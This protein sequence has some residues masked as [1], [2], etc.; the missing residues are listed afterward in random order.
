MYETG[1]TP[2]QFDKW[3][4]QVFINEKRSLKNNL[5]SNGYNKTSF[6]KQFKS[7]QDFENNN[8][9]SLD[10]LVNIYDIC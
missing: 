9:I 6:F 4:C 7:K 2:C 5:L 10:P 8:C 3:N 1:L